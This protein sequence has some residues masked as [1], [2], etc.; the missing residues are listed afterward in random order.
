M[1]C[2]TRLVSGLCAFL[3]LNCLSPPG[4]RVAHAEGVTANAAVSL[5]AYN[6]AESPA[7]REDLMASVAGSLNYGMQALPLQMGV[8]VQG[9]LYFSQA[10]IY[11]N[12][13]TNSRLRLGAGGLFGVMPGGYHLIGFPVGRGGEFAVGFEYLRGSAFTS[14]YPQNVYTGW[15]QFWA[16]ND[17]RSSVGV[18]LQ[19][20]M[21]TGMPAQLCTP[22]SPTCPFDLSEHGSLSVKTSYLLRVGF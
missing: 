8:N 16:A 21:A 6:F 17:S 22:P 4:K 19:Y 7:N 2:N 3:L 1:Q 13:I 11:Y 20:Q 5:G 12:Y 10:D 9:G 18:A 15:L 14:R